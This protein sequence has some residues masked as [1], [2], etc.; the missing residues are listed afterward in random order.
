MQEILPESHRM[1]HADDAT[2]KSGSASYRER[3]LLI[4]RWRRIGL[5]VCLFLA[6]GGLLSILLDSEFQQP[7]TILVVNSMFVVMAA[8]IATINLLAFLH[9]N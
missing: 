2:S 9:R 7:S 1:S 3:M 6:A 8:I 5:P 4:Q